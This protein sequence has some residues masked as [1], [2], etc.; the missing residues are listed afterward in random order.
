MF[1]LFFTLLWLFPTNINAQSLIT[2]QVLDENKKPLPN[3]NIL[4]YPHDKDM[5]IA[6]GVSDQLGKFKITLKVDV[7]SL[8]IEATSMHYRNH[9]ILIE[10]KTQEVIFELVPEVKI[11]EEFIVKADAIEKRGDTISYLVT[12]F[13]NIQDRS[14]SDVIKRMPGI[15][16][17]S[18]GRILYQGDPIQHLYVEGLDL[19]GGR[20][21]MVTNNMP[22]TSVSTVEILENH[23]PIK[24]LEDVAP[25]NRASL[26]IKLKNNVSTTGT[27]KLGSGLSPLLWEANVTPMLFT[28]KYQMVGSYQ[29]NNSGED[30]SS[31][32]KM[33]GAGNSSIVFLSDAGNPGV[34]S[35]Q[36]INPPGFSTNRYL[37][38]NIHL[39]NANS[40]VRIKSDITLRANLFYVFDNQGQKGITYRTLYTPTDTLNFTE[41]VNNDFRYSYT[42]GEFTLNRNTKEN[43]LNN[44]TLFK[45]HFDKFSG[46]VSKADSPLQQELDNP[47]YSFSN[48]LSVIKPINNKFIN[49]SSDISY[50]QAPQNLL[51]SPGQFADL[52]NDSVN[53][54]SIHQKSNLQNIEAL[55]S[56]SFSS[57]YKRW[58]FTPKIGLDYKQNNLDTDLFIYR[59][60]TRFATDSIFSNNLSGVNYRAYAQTGAV[61]KR[62]SFTFSSDIPINYVN[63]KIEDL[64]LDKNRSID[65]FTFNPRVNLHYKISG[66]WQ[67]SGSYGYGTHFGEMQSMHF[68]YI[69]KSHN[70]MQINDAPLSVSKRH[71]VSANISHRNPIESFFSSASYFFSVNNTNLMYNNTFLDD[72]TSVLVFTEMPNTSYSHSVNAQTSKFFRSIRSTISLNVRYSNHNRKQLVNNSMFTSINNVYDASPRLNVKI[73]DW[74]NTEYKSSVLYYDTYM[75]SRKVSGLLISKHFMDILIFPARNQFLTIKGEYYYHEEKNNYFFDLQYRYTITKRKIDI[76]FRWVNIFNNSSYRD[77]HVGAYSLVENHY[78]LRPSQFVLSV[79]FGF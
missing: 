66:F 58:T 61:Y 56:L 50:E 27:A 59:G 45:A 11:L 18:S 70:S 72:G 25:S 49:V 73:T 30:V 34:L 65:G 16:V 64:K 20:Y 71:M 10:N 23:Q 12:S 76:D 8:K 44:K 7:D 36:T 2:G 63:I 19:M 51:V 32:L 31:Q 41:I 39:V 17:E 68:G 79:K 78:I 40:L 4:V 55:H 47:F 42:Q 33:L 35:M 38:N 37:D 46:V 57:T 1:F 14:I 9:S 28:R 48:N 29:A 62:G 52:L 24:I 6:F 69:L 5:L 54:K 53:Y 74:L 3:I 13:A 22:H 43:Y 67:A 21:G 26:N 60:D 75:D 15:T 77:Y